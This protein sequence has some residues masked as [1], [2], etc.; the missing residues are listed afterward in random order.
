MSK[1][2]YSQS[3]AILLLLTEKSNAKKLV[4]HLNPNI[5]VAASINV[6]VIEIKVIKYWKQLNIYRMSL[7]QYFEMEKIESLC[8]MSELTTRM[9]LKTQPRSLIIEN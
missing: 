7:V 4:H 1:I 9:K 5:R 2:K 3:L 6:K 8:Q